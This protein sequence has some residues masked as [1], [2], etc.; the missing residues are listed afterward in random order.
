MTPYSLDLR[1]R[2]LAAVDAGEMSHWDVA[3]RFDVSPAWIRRLLQRRRETGE[4]AAKPHNGGPA[5]KLNEEHRQ[6]L[7][8]LIGKQCDATL[9][10]LA[11]SLERDKGVKVC[12]ATICRVLQALNLPLKKSRSTP[13]NRR[14][15]TCKSNEASTPLP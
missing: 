9:K 15:L 5:P 2:V 12:E 4:I 13:A 11:E 7:V 8:L 3:V 10:Q 6:H 14:G 1:K